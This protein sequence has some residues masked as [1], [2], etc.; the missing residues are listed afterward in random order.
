MFA[1]DSNKHTTRTIESCRRATAKEKTKKKNEKIKNELFFCCLWQTKKET[2]I[3]FAFS[4]ADISRR[5]DLFD[6]MFC[7]HCVY[8]TS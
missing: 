4:A 5:R 2:K 1:H 8:D 7:V 6:F 3:Q